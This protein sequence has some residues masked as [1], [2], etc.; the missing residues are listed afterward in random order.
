[1]IG[2]Q[3]SD[4]KT[5]MHVF[6]RKEIEENLDQR[7]KPYINAMYT[8]FLK[9]MNYFNVSHDPFLKNAKG[10]VFPSSGIIIF[11]QCSNIL[12]LFNFLP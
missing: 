1:M 8:Q 12:G 4:T 2:F 10:E 5:I 11:E 7:C 6:V 9:I 3:I